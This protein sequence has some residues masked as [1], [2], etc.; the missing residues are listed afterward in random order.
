MGSEFFLNFYLIVLGTNR[1]AS[2]VV[3]YKKKRLFA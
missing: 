1:E 2:L 3:K